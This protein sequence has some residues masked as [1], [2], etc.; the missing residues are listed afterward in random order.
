M[1]ELIQIAGSIRE[2]LH[3]PTLAARVELHI[4]GL[5]LDGRVSPGSRVIEEEL[6]RELGISRASL[7]EAMIGLEQAGLVSRT[8]KSGRSIRRLTD[9]DVKE[10]YQLWTI[11]EPEAA[12]LACM[13]AT[14]LDHA[15]I[16]TI[17]SEMIDAAH[18]RKAYHR[19]NLA[20]HRALVK[21]CD[22]AMLLQSYYACIKQVSWA[23]A[24][25]ISKA[26]D[27][28]V[29]IG[30]HQEIADAYFSRN[31]EDTRR[32]VREHL[33]EGALRTHSAKPS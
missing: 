12:A 30:E 25:A 11:L 17:M 13:R 18:D 33:T 22:N 5:I 28:D 24:L 8:G 31:P 29:S 20:F 27:P 15:L 9:R 19:L 6:A 2:A 10:L 3:Q 21:P 32:L 4:E 1:S 14:D 16:R 23:W 7:R 26:G